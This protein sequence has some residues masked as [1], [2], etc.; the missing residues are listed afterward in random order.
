MPRGKTLELTV[1]STS[2]KTAHFK[3]VAPGAHFWLG[4]LRAQG[5]PGD[6][7]P[8]RSPNGV[9]TQS[10]EAASG[11]PLDAGWYHRE[12]GSTCSLVVDQAKVSLLNEQS[13]RRR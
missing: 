11:L 6:R 1:S 7:P 12:G 4:T 10:R 5:N 8:E 3:T 2:L 13:R 9:V